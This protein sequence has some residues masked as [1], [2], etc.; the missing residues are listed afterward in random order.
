MVTGR[1]R[2]FEND[3]GPM[4]EI[5]TMFTV[6]RHAAVF[7]VEF[8]AETLVVSFLRGTGAGAALSRIERQTLERARGDQSEEE[9]L[10]VAAAHLITALDVFAVGWSGA[11]IRSEIAVYVISEDDRASVLGFSDFELRAIGP[12]ATSE[13][14]GGAAIAE[15]GTAIAVSVPLAHSCTG[16]FLDEGARVVSFAPLTISG[17]DCGL[18]AGGTDRF[19]WS[20]MPIKVT[21]EWAGQA[22]A[23]L[24]A[25]ALVAKRGVA[26]DE[27]DYGAIVGFG[28]DVE[29]TVVRWLW[30]DLS[31]GL[32][33]PFVWQRTEQLYVA[34]FKAPMGFGGS[35]EDELGELFGWIM[36]LDRASEGEPRYI[37]TDA[38]LEAHGCF[39]L[40]L[41][42][43]EGAK[44]LE[45]CGAALGQPPAI[46]HWAGLSLRTRA[47]LQ[48]VLCHA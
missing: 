1:L 23:E 25:A 28:D 27:R 16:V 42:G 37:M 12:M 8:L 32:D 18:V 21:P 5:P 29:R 17:H 24:T 43:F 31:P 41:Q 7:Q 38:E 19:R 34:S 15:D 6:S 2:S 36:M 48:E 26:T 9:L 45:L 20:V 13:V 47:L 46:A 3:L 33:D 4:L 40:N 44:V 35:E 14:E 22:P 11:D 30:D 10:G 39:Q